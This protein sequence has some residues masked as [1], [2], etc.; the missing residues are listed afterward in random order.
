MMTIQ[1]LSS[2]ASNFTVLYAEDDK[3]IRDNI[4]ETLEAIFTNVYVA[5]N[6]TEGI[7]LSQNNH[8]DIIISDIKMPV[9]NGFEMIKTIKKNYP[10]VAT[11]LLTGYNQHDYLL[12]SIEL[13][14]NKY[15]IKPIVKDKL[16][17]AIEDILYLLNSREKYK[18]EQLCLNKDIKMI[19][20]SKL[21]NNLAHQWRQSLSIIN[22]SLDLVS[23]NKTAKIEEENIQSIVLNAQKHITKMDDILK[24]VFQ[25]YENSQKKEYV[26]FHLVINHCLEKF[27]TKFQKYSIGIQ[28]NIQNNLEYFLQIDT[29][30]H[31]VNNI[32]ENAIDA[33]I[34]N[35]IKNGI[36][37][38]HIYKQEEF[39]NLDISDNAGGI[40]KSIQDEIF[41]PY[42]TTKNSYIG[43]GLGLYIVYVLTTKSLQGMISAVNINGGSKFSISLPYR[44]K[45]L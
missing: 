35:K 14:I 25:E 13:S 45:S 40:K 20:I 36:I 12:Q 34:L 7:E 43:T 33:I 26:D 39:L 23:L 8:I 30:S 2:L 9:C 41:E 28:I 6:G 38:I 44:I 37:S 11:I 29:F 10:Q 27:Q 32:L 31:I 18:K 5:S 4:Q 19:A 24:D 16:F 17:G 15:L 1:Q 22:I 3:E 42:T 21:L